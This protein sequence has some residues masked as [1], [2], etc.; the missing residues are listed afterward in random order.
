MRLSFC[1]RRDIGVRV[2]KEAV[3]DEKILIGALLLA[4]NCGKA[5]APEPKTEAYACKVEF[6]GGLAYDAE[7]KSWQSTT[8]KPKGKFIFRLK[9]VKTETEK[10][11]SHA[12]T[13]EATVTEAGR[14]REVSCAGG[15]DKTTSADQDGT[16]DCATALYQYR[17]NLKNN[18]FLRAYLAGYVNGMNENS[19]TPGVSGGTCIKID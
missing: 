15:K 10:I 11:G 17:F 19:D 1:E 18:R 12:V 2:D 6:T 4:L 9:L 7:S 3:M 8:F 16:L 5:E 14:N 13:Y